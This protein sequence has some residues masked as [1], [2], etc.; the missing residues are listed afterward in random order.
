MNHNFVELLKHRTASIK[1]MQQ[2]FTEN[3]IKRVAILSDSTTQEIKN[4]VLYFCLKRNINL[5]FFEDSFGRLFEESTFDSSRLFTFK[6]D[7]VIL[8]PSSDRYI[9]NSYNYDLEF[10]NKQFCESK[11]KLQT[12]ISNLKQL[13][14]PLIFCNF[15]Y[16]KERVLGNLD[17]RHP[18]GVNAQIR[19]LNQLIEDLVDTNESCYLCDVHYLSA[20]HGLSNWEDKSQ[21]FLFKYDMSQC[22]IMELGDELSKIIASLLGKSKKLLICDLDNTLWG[23]ILGEDGIDGIQIGSSSVQSEIYNEIQRYI[24][25]LKN[26]GI[27]LAICSKNNEQDVIEVFNNKSMILNLTDFSSI[28]ANWDRKSINITKIASE[29]SLGIDSFVMLDDNPVEREEI[30]STI[31]EV[32]VVDLSKSLNFVEDLDR[33]GFFEPISITDDDYKRSLMYKERKQRE[34][35]KNTFADYSEYLKSL[36]MINT[37]EYISSSTLDRCVQLINKTNQF[38]LTTQRLNKDELIKFLSEENNRGILIRSKDKFGDNGI[39]SVMLVSIINKEVNIILWLMSCRVIKRDIEKDAISA[40]YKYAQ[41]NQLALIRG[42]YKKSPKNDLVASLYS[43]LGFKIEAYG[44][45]D[46]L[47]SLNVTD[48]PYKTSQ[49]STLINNI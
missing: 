33:S 11:E 42:K 16:K 12:I 22:A 3:N 26:R 27:I 34:E 49:V 43:D 30:R 25:A 28:K 21:K 2:T 40:L 13:N 19:K 15:P 17:T 46:A 36:E 44:E 45:S 31:S 18:I 38:N 24:L 48:E 37:I 32:A 5:E 1:L 8:I 14:I 35:Y 10:I 47:Y 6:P 29:L 9:N 7:I 4:W 39:I 23:G 41:D 20:Y